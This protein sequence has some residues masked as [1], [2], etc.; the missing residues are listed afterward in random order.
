MNLL[1]Q[2]LTIDAVRLDVDVTSRK[3]LFEEAAFAV[4]TA[5]GEDHDAVFDALMARER[6]GSTAL[7]NGCAI[8][9]GRLASLTSPA[10]V[11]LRT[12]TPISYDAPDNRPVRLFMTILV[13]SK[14]PQA[15][16]TL[17]KE[18][19]ALFSDKVVLQKILAASEALAVCK[20]I[21]DWQ[22]P[23]EGDTE[24]PKENI[25]PKIEMVATVT[26]S[27]KQ[28]GSNKDNTDRPAD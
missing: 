13:P 2:Y 22:S 3:R 1:A 11:L 28:N 19:A 10:I 16:L 20:L 4:E 24:I 12:K 23:F 17:L 27:E 14:D 7:G 25:K 26:S 9:H 18:T 8:P 15:H 21:A 6:L 5:Y